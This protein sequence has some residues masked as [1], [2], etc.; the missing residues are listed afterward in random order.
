[1]GMLSRQRPILVT[2][3]WKRVPTGTNGGITAWGTAWSGIGGAIMGLSNVVMDLLSGL[4]PIQPIRTIAFGCLCGLLGSLVDSLLG[5]TVQASYWDPETK[6]S[7]QSDN[8]PPTAKHVCGFNLLSNAQVNL[9]SV[10]VMTA[11]GGY[12]IGPLVFP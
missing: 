2:K 9:A 4:T 6:L 7:Y 10:V 1:M 12:I 8:C 5:A 11:A 3:P